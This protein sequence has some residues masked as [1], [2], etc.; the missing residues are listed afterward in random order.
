MTHQPSG[1]LALLTPG[2]ASPNCTAKCEGGKEHRDGG[3]KRRDRTGR[4]P[5]EKHAH[6]QS[7]CACASD[8]VNDHI[9]ARASRHVRL[10]SSAKQEQ[11][12]TQNPVL[13][14]E[15]RDMSSDPNWENVL[16]PLADDGIDL[17]HMHDRCPGQI[18][19]FHAMMR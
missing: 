13:L 6:V 3:R 19:C 1:T 2:P 17:R 9:C 5:N 11:K 12:C 10:F 7:G 16:A 18:D 15:R 4:G 14:H 8:D